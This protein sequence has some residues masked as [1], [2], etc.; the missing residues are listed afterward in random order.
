LRDALASISGI[1]LSCAYDIPEP[2]AG[3]T[4]DLSKVNVLFTPPGAER[5]LIPQ[6]PPGAGCSTGWRYS[7]DQSQ[8]LLC[9]DTCDQ[10]SSST[11]QL[12]LEFGCTTRVIF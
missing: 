9:G 3:E 12:E 8:V 7:D 1:A 11:G 5:E 6:S 4:L 2:P 10:V